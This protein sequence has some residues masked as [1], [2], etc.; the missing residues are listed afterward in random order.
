M[1]LK[2]EQESRAREVRVIAG[3]SKSNRKES[4]LPQW[5]SG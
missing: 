5:S 3:I 2:I 1:T 4:G